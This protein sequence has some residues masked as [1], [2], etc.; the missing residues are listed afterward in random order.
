MPVISVDDWRVMFSTPDDPP[1][2]ATIE[3]AIAYAQAEAEGYCG[4]T[5]DLESQK[6]RYWIRYDEPVVLN[7]WP[8]NDVTAVMVDGTEQDD[9]SYFED[10]NLHRN[11]GRLCHDGRL[12][13]TVIEITYSAGYSPAPLPL[14]RAVGA[15]AKQQID[16]AVLDSG[17][18]SVSR[19]TV[20]GV[21]SVEYRGYGSEVSMAGVP[22]HLEPY[23]AVLNRYKNIRIA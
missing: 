11:V 10:E 7:R 3:Q 9:L 1:S 22:P 15:L 23:V 14:Q 16:D 17:D 5:F 13:G 2:D 6:E 21:A 8:V 12:K 4:R 20:Y 19:E 18:R